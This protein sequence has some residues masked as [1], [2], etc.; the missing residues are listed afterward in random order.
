MHHTLPRLLARVNAVPVGAGDSVSEE[1]RTRRELFALGQLA[2]QEATISADFLICL[3]ISSKSIDDLRNANPFIT[4]VA[5]AEIFDELVWAVL[6]AS[7]VGQLNRC[8][9]DAH[10]LLA[11]LTPRAGTF[12][13]EAASALALKSQSLA[14]QMMTRRHYVDAHSD[15]LLDEHASGMGLVY[16]P[17]YLLFEFTHNIVLRKAQ[18]ELVREFVACVREGRPLVK[19]MLMGGG[20]TTVVGPLLAVMLADGERLVIQTMPPALLEQ[21]KA[22]LRATFSSIVRK[23]VFTLAFDR[24][25]EMRW[26]TVDK[27]QSAARNRGVVL[28][29]ASTIKALQL[30][31]LEKMDCLRDEQR[32]HHPDMERDVRAIAQ[33]LDLFQSGCLIMDEVDLLL[34]PLKSE[35]KYDDRPLPLPSV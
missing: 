25:S 27:L 23:R 15:P 1:E 24:S 5:A 3:L 13:D 28:C 30:K 9:S 2:M 11:L 18:V 34:H 12:G 31:M 8:L 22:T 7:R 17:R 21:S 14:E 32:T 6:H 4:P 33:V 20:K 10:G 29:T 19:Q 16:D 35:L 26:A